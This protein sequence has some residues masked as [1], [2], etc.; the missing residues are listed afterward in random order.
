MLWLLV[1]NEI[2]FLG[3]QGKY[4]EVS[5]FAAEYPL[6]LF[7]CVLFRKVTLIEPFFVTLDFSPQNS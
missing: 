1:K 6:L 7:Q 5:Y 4:L 2:L 3:V